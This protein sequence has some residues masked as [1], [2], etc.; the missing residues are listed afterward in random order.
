MPSTTCLRLPPAWRRFAAAAQIRDDERQE[1]RD[2]QQ[3]EADLADRRP[4]RFQHDHREEVDRRDGPREDLCVAEGRS[5]HGRPQRI[6]HS[7]G[8]SHDRDLDRDGRQG[9]DCVEEGR[10]IRQAV[11]PEDRVGDEA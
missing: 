5:D 7:Q 9:E 3:D 8:G 10:R 6:G 1:E 11:G 4:I 2:G